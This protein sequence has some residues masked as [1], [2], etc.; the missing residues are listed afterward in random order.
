MFEDFILYKTLFPL[1]F[2]V[3]VKIFFQKILKVRFLADQ[4]EF[5]GRLV[6]GSWCSIGKI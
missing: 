2:N 3:F 1:N 5:T 6:T 4:A